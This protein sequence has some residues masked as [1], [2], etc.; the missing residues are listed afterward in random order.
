[1]F[2]FFLRGVFLS[3]LRPEKG[4]K[5]DPGGRLRPADL[6][7]NKKPQSIGETSIGDQKEKPN[8]FIKKEK[9]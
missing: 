1:M 6:H 9:K 3:L 2:L 4:E 8:K 5:L 7:S